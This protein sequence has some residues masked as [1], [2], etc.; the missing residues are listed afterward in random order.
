MIGTLGGS[1][2]YVVGAG[3]KGFGL[4]C[5]LLCFWR[6]FVSRCT[7]PDDL[8]DWYRG[9]QE[10]DLF[11]VSWVLYFPYLIHSAQSELLPVALHFEHAMGVLVFML[12][13][14]SRLGL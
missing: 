1:S 9:E 13:L 3:V 12:Q 5:G 2:N 6:A 7:D 4:H 14:I 10:L 11:Y 8:F